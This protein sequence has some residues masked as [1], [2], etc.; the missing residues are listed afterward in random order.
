MTCR[1]VL[2][3]TALWAA[4]VLAADPVAKPTPEQVEFFEKKVR[5][6][7]ADHCYSCHGPDSGSRRGALRL[8]DEAWAKKKVIVPGDPEHSPVVQRIT[9]ADPRQRMPF[10]QR[11]ST[12]WDVSSTFTGMSGMNGSRSSTTRSGCSRRAWHSVAGW[13]IDAR[14]SAR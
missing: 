10:G 13:M 2:S 1:F 5:P 3:L 14:S 11:P 7:L 4:P 6:L 9:A 8:D 12:G